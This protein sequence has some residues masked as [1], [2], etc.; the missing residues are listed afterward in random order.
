MSY[1]SIEK[2]NT[3]IIQPYIVGSGKSAKA[4]R[5][6]LKIL[7][8]IEPGININEPIQIS[9][10]QKLPEV[11]S[12]NQKNCLFIANPPA[13]HTNLII[14]AIQSRWEEI[15]T[16][17]P[18]AISTEQ[19]EILDKLGSS[20]L[21]SIAVLHCYRQTW[22]FLKLKNLIKDNF[23][24][25]L[26]SI[27]GRYWQS[28]VA[29]RNKEKVFYE[30]W[31]DNSELAG[32]YD[33]LTDLSC[34]WL[35]FASALAG[36]S[37]PIIEFRNLDY[38]LAESA[39]RDT[40]VLIAGKFKENKC[41]FISSISKIIHG[42]R[43]DFEISVIGTKACAHWAFQSPDQIELGEGSSKRIIMCEGEKIGSEF[44][45]FHRMG[46]IEGY[47]ETLRQYFLYKNNHNYP[48]LGEHLK[49]MNSLLLPSSNN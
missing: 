30:T 10:N 21:E 4:I 37:T 20:K 14:E 43:N 8:S 7:D 42:A 49:I 35:D 36:Y 13:L 22:G 27:E 16:E 48:N 39:H 17:K 25:E 24:G 29:K 9:R 33:T 26:I 47:I 5:I 38:R 41:S 18:G 34:H 40:H 32:K 6:S 3:E 11:N 2:H 31:K 45:S 12:Q 23:L 44:D 15:V 28:S 19:I 1:K 46:W